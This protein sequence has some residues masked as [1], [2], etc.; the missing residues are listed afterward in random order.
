MTIQ[1]LLKDSRID[2]LESGH[3][4]CRPGWVQIKECPFCHSANYHLGFSLAAKFFACWKCGGHQGRATLARLGVDR[5]KAQALLKGAGRAEWSE[6]KRAELKEPGGRIDLLPAHRRYLK[7]RGF[8]P[9]EV[10]RIWKVEGIGLAA[11]LSWRLYLPIIERGERVSWTTRAIGDKVEQR[12]IS[13]AADQEALS[14][15][16]L[17]YGLDYCFH[18]AVIVEGPIDAWAIGPGGA[19]LFGTAF[20]AGQ[21]A[22]LARIPYRYIVFDSSTDAQVRAR[23]LCCS[24]SCFPG[25][26]ELIELDAKDPG[27]ASARELSLLRKHARL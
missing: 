12:Y 15:K 13:A 1:E 24:L 19:A 2:F 18:A 27:S 5:D 7:G 10:Q 14:H 11:R 26:T 8:D 3:H 6:T 4:H 21:V 16:Q 23:S 25:T 17:V 22:R 9:D 20:T